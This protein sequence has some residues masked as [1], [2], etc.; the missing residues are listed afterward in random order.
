MWRQET[1]RRSYCLERRRRSR[2]R[3]NPGHPLARFRATTLAAFAPLASVPG[4]TFYSLQKGEAKILAKEQIGR[5]ASGGESVMIISAARQHRARGDEDDS[6]NVVLRSSYDL[7]AARSAVDRLEQSYGG[8]D[9]AT[10]LQL[11]VRL[12]KEE[13]NQPQ[14]FLYVLTDF[15]RSAWE[16]NE[17]EIIRRTGTDIAATF[18]GRV[19]V[20]DLGRPGQWNYAV[21]DLRPDGNLV[22][23]K[24][25][26]DFLAN[27]K[28]FG[29][30]PE[31]M[32]QWKWDEEVLPEGGRVKPDLSTEI[33]RQTQAQVTEGGAHILSV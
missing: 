25:H 24:F 27:V 30:G 29:N 3:S 12:A 22:T 13:Q 26:T 5:L 19:R 7:E 16:T 11:A 23:N 33:Q 15:T 28:G 17:A 18:G 31:S 32:V 21:L 10:A 14:K 8:T 2:L 20:H 9:M 6:A 4:V 1:W